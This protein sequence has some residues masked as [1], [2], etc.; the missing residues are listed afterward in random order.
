MVGLYTQ[1][2]SSPPRYLITGAREGLGGSWGGGT[3]A[4]RQEKGLVRIGTEVMGERG[5]VIQKNAT[6]HS[7]GETQTT[8]TDGKNEKKKKKRKNA[9]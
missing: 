6:G 9:G 7:D 5:G 1:S 4:I 8:A 3:V 2:K